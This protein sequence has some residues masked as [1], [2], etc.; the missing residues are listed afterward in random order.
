[1][2]T[3][4]QNLKMT[5]RNDLLELLQR[6]EELFDG[7]HGTRKTDP[8]DFEL[9]RIRSQYDCNNTQYPNYTRKCSKK[10]LAI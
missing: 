1:M 3:Q 6:F 7:T 8:V 9:N 10:R 2:D 4:C 5:Q